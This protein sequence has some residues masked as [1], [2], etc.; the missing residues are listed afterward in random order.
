MYITCVNNLDVAKEYQVAQVAIL[1]TERNERVFMSLT[2][3]NHT[4]RPQ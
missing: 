2:S 3:D 4:M 1:R